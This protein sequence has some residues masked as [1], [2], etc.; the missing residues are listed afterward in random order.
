MVWQIVVNQFKRQRL[1]ANK[2]CRA[3]S[4]P[5]LTF[6]G[7]EEGYGPEE[8]PPKTPLPKFEEDIPVL[9]AAP[10]ST[11]GKNYCHRLRKGGWTPSVIEPMEASPTRII[12]LVPKDC[13]QMMHV[14][15]YYGVFCTPI[16]LVVIPKDLLLEKVRLEVKE[17]KTMD[18]IPEDETYR[19]LPRIVHINRCGL[20]VENIVFLN[21]PREQIVR[22]PV[23]VV[24]TGE[25]ESPAKKSGNYISQ[26]KFWLNV[27]CRG[28]QI[29]S[30]IEVDVS[31]MKFGDE[32]YAKDLESL[33]PEGVQMWR[34]ETYGEELYL[35]IGFLCKQCIW[36]E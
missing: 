28:D 11:T 29:P 16:K 21:C 26:V 4:Q 31:K 27:E 6:L 20:F 12:R 9:Y 24:L 3:F 33:L 36:K 14:F 13:I 34:K 19:V 35:K 30:K 15:G 18:S 17:G 8:G 2:F 7:Y 5:A 25:E 22:V 1:G 10:R 23:Q 32:V